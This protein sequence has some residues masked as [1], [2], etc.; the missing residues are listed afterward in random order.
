MSS[1][2]LI[3]FSLTLVVGILTIISFFFGRFIKR[4]ES[5]ANARDSAINTMVEHFDPTSE[6]SKHLG[7]TMSERMM[8]MASDV[9]EIKS[10]VFHDFS[11]DIASIKVQINTQ[12]ID[13]KKNRDELIDI[14]ERLKRL[15]V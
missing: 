3:G 6:L 7:G 9:R 1:I 4:F 5:R 12:S 15:D 2:Q 14:K 10:T 8:I 11:K 13:I